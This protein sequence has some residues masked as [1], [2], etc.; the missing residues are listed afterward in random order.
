MSIIAVSHR[1]G[2]R[3]SRL[4]T[5]IALAI[6]AHAARAAESPLTLS[7]A[8]AIGVAAAPLLSARN[9]DVAAA[10]EQA[11]AAGRLPDPALSFGVA[12]YP[13]TSPGAFGWRSDPMTMRTVGVTQMIPSYASRRAAR[14]LAGAK[15]DAALADRLVTAQS[16]QERVADAWIGVWTQEQQQTLLLELRDE[17]KLAVKVTQARL[18]GGAGSATDVL[19]AR[20][21]LLALDNR[22]AASAAALAAAEASLARWLGGPPGVLAAPPDFAHLPLNPAQLDRAVDRQA[23]LQR[24]RARERAAQA[25]VAEAR[26]SKHPDWSVGVSYGNRAVGESDMVTWEVGLSLPLFSR[27]RQDRAIGAKTAELQSARSAYEDARRAETESVQRAAALWLGWG[28]QIDRDRDRLLPLA[29]DRTRL[30]LADY[31]GGGALESWLDARRDEIRER[32]GYVE[33]L[34]A[35]AELWASLAYLMPNREE[36]P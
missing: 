18:R 34:D 14:E 32:L 27:D 4:A 8:V 11:V 22:L 10:R 25:A 23:P 24:W 7:A 9:A 26:A 21:A 6:T 13:V 20:A 5:F 31:R 15:T 30:A 29:R 12:N 1:A 33:A 17:G 16:V 2:A 3:A 36:A 19:A 28:R 35:R